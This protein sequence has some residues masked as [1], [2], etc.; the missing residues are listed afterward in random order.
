[1]SS[2][3]LS[4]KKLERLVAMLESLFAGANASIEAPSRRLIDRDTG[5]SREHDVLI[6]WDHG[7]HRIITA[8]ECRD[9][10]R[11]VGV[12]AVEAFADKCART[13]VHSGVIVSATGFTA[14]ARSKAE[15]RSI[16]CMDLA[17]VNGFDW[18]A[19]ELFTKFERKFDHFEFCIMFRDT[20]PKALN[21]IFDAGGSPVSDQGLIQTVMN[22]VAQSANP[23][24][25][26]DKTFTVNIHLKTINWTARD[27]DGNIWE[28]DHILAKA[29]FTTHKTVGGVQA[30]RYSGGGKDYSVASTDFMLGDMAGKFVM[31][32]NEDETISVS[33]VPDKHG[34][35]NQIT[36]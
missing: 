1:M 15:A 27:T 9:R 23:E 20:Q 24:D 32:R 28:I 35:S 22:R 4:G 21:G 36:D 11:P 26:V 34:R 29:S 19:V 13:G 17:E 3:D 16:T 2:K 18:M 33:W 12:P 8:I 30:H 5:R 6:M 10:S 25:E 7:H 14:T 31:M